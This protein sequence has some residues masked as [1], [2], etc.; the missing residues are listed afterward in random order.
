M[1]VLFLLIFL[2]FFL[3]VFFYVLVCGNVFA[4]AV[5]QMCHLER[6]PFYTLSKHLLT[7]DLQPFATLLRNP[8][9]LLEKV[10]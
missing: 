2:V 5:L 8:L 7:K 1:L 3:S 9:I 4:N 10:C 6:L